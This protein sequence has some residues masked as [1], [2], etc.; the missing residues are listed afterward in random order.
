MAAVSGVGRRPGRWWSGVGRFRRIVVS[1]VAWPGCLPG[2]EA[3][4]L[5]GA[6][7]AVGC[8][9]GGC[10]L[11]RVWPGDDLKSGSA[12]SRGCCVLVAHI[13]DS[14]VGSGGGVHHA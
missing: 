12:S 4:E 9:R 7:I 5:S 1:V 8:R 13:S 2:I 14:T 10:R 3:D 6:E 11:M